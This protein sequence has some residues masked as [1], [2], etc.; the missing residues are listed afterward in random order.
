MSTRA[1]W[2]V[3]V[4]FALGACGDDTVNP[5]NPDA[6]PSKDATTDGADKDGGDG[7]HTDAHADARGD[8][9]GDVQQNDGE[10]GDGGGVGDASG[11]D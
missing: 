7:G 5:S 11:T 9:E 6:G 1:F 2:A 8:A 4:A 10:T 3:A